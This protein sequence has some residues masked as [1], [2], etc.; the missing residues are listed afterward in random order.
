VF[1]LCR[2]ACQQSTPVA[3][4]KDVGCDSSVALPSFLTLVITAGEVGKSGQE[5]RET[6]IDDPEL[7][8]RH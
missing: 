6:P 4:L 5:G 8:Y 7:F 2:V 3:A 1:R